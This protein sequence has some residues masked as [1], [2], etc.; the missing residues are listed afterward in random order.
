M[1]ILQ[2]DPAGSGG[3]REETEGGQGGA[4]EAAQ[5]EGESPVMGNAGRHLLIGADTL[6]RTRLSAR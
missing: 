3:D 1:I 2:P 5:R 4:G 6:R